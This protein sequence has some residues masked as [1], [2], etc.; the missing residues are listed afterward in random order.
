M[1]DLTTDERAI[2][3]SAKR[4]VK[5]TIRHHVEMLVWRGV[6]RDEA[7]RLIAEPAPWETPVVPLTEP[8]QARPPLG[9][10]RWPYF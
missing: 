4:S 1:S 9:K 8:A 10:G 5:N 6:P 2:V 3:H 7:E